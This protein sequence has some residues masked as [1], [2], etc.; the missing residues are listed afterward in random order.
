MLQ[1]SERVSDVVKKVVMLI[2]NI[3]QAMFFLSLCYNAWKANP[4]I[5]PQVETEHCLAV[6]EEHCKRVALLHCNAGTR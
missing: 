1:K 6:V 2:Q 4:C 5:M 3:C